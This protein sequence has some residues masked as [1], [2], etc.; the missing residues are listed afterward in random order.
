M[1][2]LLS[3]RVEIHKIR[4]DGRQVDDARS[5]PR[6]AQ[7]SVPKMRPI[8]LSE[9]NLLDAGE[10][11]LLYV[12]GDPPRFVDQTIRRDDDLGGPLT[13]DHH[14]EERSPPRDLSA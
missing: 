10:R 2:E 3:T 7:T 5:G 11:D 9:R 12:T 13:A 14:D 6:D 4:Q 1:R 8:M